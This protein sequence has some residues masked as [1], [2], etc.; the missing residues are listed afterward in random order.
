MSSLQVNQDARA[1]IARHGF[2]FLP[3]EAWTLSPQMQRA[4]EHLRDDWHHLELDRYL[5]DGAT[6]RRRRY[7]R[8]YWSPVEDAL[9]PLPNEAYFQPQDE[10]N[11]AGGIVREFAPLRAESVHNP[12]LAELVRL[13][14]GCLPLP[15]EKQGKIW[16]VR[17]HQIRI[18]AS[19]HE[20]GE[21]TPEG[22]H[23]DGTDFL[24][25]HLVRRDNVTGAE[26]TIY[27]LDRRPIYSVTLREP[28]DSFIIEDPRV[29]HGVTPIHP[30]DPGSPGN[31]DL[32]GIDFIYSPTLGRPSEP[33]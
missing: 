32:F 12:F 21:P 20:M 16:E 5:K 24:T 30:V 33:A 23:Q 28:L 6:F 14:F 8:Y 3:G 17:V 25:L 31:R 4:W 11:Y 26:S 18:V 15:I 19:A 13:T 22:I 10:N 27:D 7:G 1:E 9:L 29:M 2:V